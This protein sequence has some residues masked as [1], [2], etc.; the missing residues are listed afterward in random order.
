MQPPETPWGQR[1]PHEPPRRLAPTGEDPFF[2]YMVRRG[3]DVMTQ[4]P[5]PLSEP[6]AIA[7]ARAAEVLEP[8]SDPPFASFRIIP[9]SNLEGGSFP[10]HKV[11]RNISAKPLGA[12]PIATL[13]VSGPYARRRSRRRHE[14][15][16]PGKVR[17]EPKL[18]HVGVDPRD[19]RSDPKPSSKLGRR[20]A[21]P[22][23]R[24]P[25]RRQRWVILRI[26]DRCGPIRAHREDA[27]SVFPLPGH[28]HHHH[29]ASPG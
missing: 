9:A 7:F 28:R 26:L 10:R 17:I 19:L 2:I 18:S 24:I 12:D 22:S 20:P 11:A 29:L 25:A 4:F 16:C 5:C 14:A 23:S 21:P 8:A 27:R 15:P 6:R 13:A 1:R 3:S